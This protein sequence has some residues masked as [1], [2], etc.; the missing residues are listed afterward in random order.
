[1][2]WRHCLLATVLTLHTSFLCVGLHQLYLTLLS[3]REE[4]FTSAPCTLPAPGHLKLIDI[5]TI[6]I[7]N[8]D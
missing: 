5:S 2:N 8:A 3:P 7:Y 6:E 4:I 1:M